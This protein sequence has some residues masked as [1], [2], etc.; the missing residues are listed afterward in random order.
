MNGDQAYKM[1]MVTFQESTLPNLLNN[2]P[3]FQIDGNLGNTAGIA[4]M[5]IQ[6]QNDEL[7]LLPALPSAWKAGCIKGLVGRGG[8]IVDMSWHNSQL[9][10]LSVFSKIGGKCTLR[11]KDKIFT[12]LAAK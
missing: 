6:S 12:F 1:L 7:V 4:E 9:S 5:L 2:H 10:S 3:P 11:Y 8:F